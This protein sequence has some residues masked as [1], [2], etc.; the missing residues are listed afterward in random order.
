[1]SD[2]R[3]IVTFLPSGL[4]VDVA[5]GTTVREASLA[6]GVHLET[7]CGGLGTCGRCTVLATG[8][9]EP[10][11]VDETVLLPADRL[12]AGE[13]LACRARVAGDVMVSVAPARVPETLKIVEAT[14]LGA[15]EVESPELRGVAGT[16]PLIGAAVDIGTTT[17]AVKLIDLS[18]GAGLGS[19]AAMN[20]QARFGHDVMSRISHAGTHGV[21]SLRKPIVEAVETLVVEAA[22]SGGHAPEHVREVAICGNTTMMHLLLG[23]DPAPL[24]AFPYEPAFLDP[25]D[26][27]AADIGLSGLAGARAYVLPGISAFLGSDVTAGLLATRLAER[28]RPAILID[29]G[30]NG[31]MVV[32]TH[33][34]L[35]AASV[36]AGPAL[37]GAT[38][39]CGM[40]AE[41]GAIERVTLAGEGLLTETIGDVGPRGLCGSGLLDLVAALLEAGVLDSTGRLRDDAPH[42]LAARVA[43]VEG[44]RAF[45][46]APDVHLTQLDVRQ[47]QLANAAVAAGVQLL[48]A[49]AGVAADDVADVVVAGG[50]GFHVRADALVRMG[51]VP[52]VWRDR[53]TFAG[54]TALAGALVALLDSGARRRA[55]AIARHVSTVD[56]A[57]HP[58]FQARFIGA[59]DFPEAR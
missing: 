24:G 42:P 44:V 4:T 16:A 6:A 8:G 27:P 33:D 54:N 11:G 35:V 46:I 56:L 58:D 12:E 45:E 25:L 32:R 51:M 52:G 22:R 31:E 10:P 41:E 19:A 38:I 15:I 36:A 50:F 2:L 40:R 55:A 47:V 59:M 49:E 43:D 17:V 20:P 48:L 3:P 57:S 18:T 21:G 29:L 5:L 53:V 7:P 37:E 26:R 28:D 1:V 39:S 34:R 23:I 14:R 13:R 9:L 30:T